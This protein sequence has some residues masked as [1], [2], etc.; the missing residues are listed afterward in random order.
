[1][2]NA[3]NVNG[4]TSEAETADDEI[5]LSQMFTNMMIA[6]KK[7]SW[8]VILLTV[9]GFAAGFVLGK[10]FYT[11]QYSANASFT[12]AS[13][14]S[15]DN[16]YGFYSSLDDQL[17]IAETY[18]ITS[19]TLKDRI[20]ETLGKEYRSAVITAEALNNTNLVTVTVTADSKEKVRSVI[21]EVISEF[22]KVSQ[23]IYGDVKVSLLDD[24]DKIDKPVNA[25]TMK[26]Y[27][28]FGGLV[29][30]VIG[31]GIAFILSLNL[32]LVSDSETLQKYVN[33]ECIGAIPQVEVKKS[34]KDTY[35][36]VRNRSVSD[37]F[38]E[39]FQFVRTRTERFFRKNGCSSLLI[40]STFPGEGKT[41]VTINTAISLSQNNKKVIVIDGD[42]R[43][44]SI[45][46][47]SGAKARKAGLD[48]VLR[49]DARLE[50][51]IIQ[52]P[53]TNVFFVSC[54]KPIGNPSEAISSQAMADIIKKAKAIADY[55]IIDSPPTDVMGDSILLSEYAD[56]AI[57]VVRQNYGNMNNVIYAIESIEQSKSELIGFVLNGS[58]AKLKMHDGYGYGN[59]GSYH[60][61]NKKASV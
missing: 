7:I 12:V 26:K 20:V 8:L 32:N 16:Y 1:M 25:G 60:N 61:Y 56:S 31:L 58:D 44:P 52:Y 34:Q 2:A 22:P 4:Y 21:D 50:D 23:K 15:G 51:A 30:L 43:N 5:E 46:A 33:C 49:G 10:L 41:T 45:I 59:Y 47:R 36:T 53:K 37:D 3:V 57:F 40:T 17:P 24:V 55:V 35:V 13:T 11:P 28:I 9:V 6:L 18:I 38:K 54:N 48:D 14:R 19:S 29:G 42:L 27:F 39:A